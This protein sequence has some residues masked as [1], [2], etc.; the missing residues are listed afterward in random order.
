MDSWLGFSKQQQSGVSLSTSEASWGARGLGNLSLP[1]T[2]I[3]VVSLGHLAWGWSPPWHFVSSRGPF[4][5]SVYLLLIL[6]FLVMISMPINGQS[7]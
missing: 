3:R 7:L 5:L 4:F 6:F 1:W 2:L